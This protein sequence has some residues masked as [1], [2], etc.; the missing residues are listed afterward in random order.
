MRQSLLPLPEGALLIDDA[1]GCRRS[2]YPGLAAWQ[3]FPGPRLSPRWLLGEAPGASAALQC[4]L[5][6][7]AIQSG[8]SDAAVVS[9]IGADQQ[10]SALVLTSK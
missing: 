5:A 9:A 2:D 4:V 8:K 1:A 10:A 6:A 3:D 7:A